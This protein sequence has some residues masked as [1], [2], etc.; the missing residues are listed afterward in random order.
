[1][2]V[3]PH[4]W[5]E[6]RREDNHVEGDSMSKDKLLVRIETD[7]YVYEEWELND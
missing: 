5:Y 4:V 2:E 1:V 7:E 3:L 6:E